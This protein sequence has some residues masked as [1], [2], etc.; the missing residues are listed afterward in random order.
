MSTVT[1]LLGFDVPKYSK[2]DDPLFSLA[3]PCGYHGEMVP[4][5]PL[6][7]N[8]FQTKVKCELISMESVK[9]DA[10]EQEN[11]TSDDKFCS[12]APGSVATGVA[13]GNSTTPAWFGKGIKVKRSLSRQ[14]KRRRKSVKS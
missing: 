10:P 5:P 8:K 2:E 3:A 4:I 14:P 6:F 11:D 7:E 9:N 12:S 1:S 13:V